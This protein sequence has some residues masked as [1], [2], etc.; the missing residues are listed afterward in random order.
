MD[1]N[2]KTLI[3]TEQATPKD[4]LAIVTFVIIASGLFGIS[5][6]SGYPVTKKFILLNNKTTYVGLA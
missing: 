6:H 1:Q 4:Q 2:T 3:I 5:I